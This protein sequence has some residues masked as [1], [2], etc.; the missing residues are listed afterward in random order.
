MLLSMVKAPSRRRVPLRSG[1]RGATR[2]VWRKI[3]LREW[4]EFR[5]FSVEGLAER[6]GVS[7]G[8]ISQIE[9]RK[10]A[11]SPDS[12][13]KLAK[14][15]DC[16][17]GELLDIKPEAGG[18]IVRLWVHDDDRAQLERVVNALSKVKP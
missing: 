15:L 7:P 10:S 5:G 17:P 9:N 12:L 3:Y 8:L 18:S 6:A 11:G 16:D 13:E 2:K 1:P 4:R 14:V